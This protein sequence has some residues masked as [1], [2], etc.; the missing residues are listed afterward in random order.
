MEKKYSYAVGKIRK[1]NE[2]NVVANVLKFRYNVTFVDKI[3]TSLS[4]WK[5]QTICLTREQMYIFKNIKDE[6]NR[7]A[8]LTHVLLFRN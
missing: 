2:K 4:N 7:R 5:E 1:V 8:F 3:P 6:D